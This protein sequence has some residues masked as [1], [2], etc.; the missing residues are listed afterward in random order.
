MWTLV[1]ITI[2]WKSYLE[3]YLARASCLARTVCISLSLLSE[4]YCFQSAMESIGS[5]ILF[6]FFFF[7]LV[8]FHPFSRWETTQGNL[9]NSTL[10]W[11]CRC[12]EFCTNA[13]IRL[14]F[15]VSI[16]ELFILLWALKQQKKMRKE[17][18]VSLRMGGKN[19]M[20]PR[21]RIMHCLYTVVVFFFFFFFNPNHP[22]SWLFIKKKL[23][24]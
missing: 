20:L 9:W 6:L 12:H 10:S 19:W 22:W 8:C 1:W 14:P 21:P 24:E 18:W 4:C 15:I 16:C 11:V 5:F 3:L 23:Y 2:S 13:S 17:I 7:L